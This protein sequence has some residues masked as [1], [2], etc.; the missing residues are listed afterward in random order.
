MMSIALS[1]TACPVCHGVE[2][3][4]RFAA[5]DPLSQDVFQLVRCTQCGLTY[6]NPRPSGD[7]LEAYYASSYYGNRH[8]ALKDT[9]MDLRARKI[10]LPE[11][12]DTV[13]DLGCGSGDFLLACRRRGW[14]TIGVEQ[15]EA[16]AVSRLRDVGIRVVSPDEM[17]SIG[18]NSINTVTAWHVLEHLPEP[19]ATFDQVRRIL[20]P[21]GRFVIEVPNFASWQARLGGPDWFHVDVPRH[22]LHFDRPSLATLLARSNFS[23]ER[24]STFSLEYDIFSLTQSLLNKVCRTP[25]HLFQL[26]IDHP[27]S[28]VVRDTLLS[29]TLVA[30]AAAIA[31]AISLVAP[32]SGNGGVLRVVARSNADA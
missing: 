23:A 25:N 17:D 11:D 24:W 7:Q 16:P 32:L 15:P 6:V 8:P 22:L 21:G 20:K 29:L 31:T 13:L 18:S 10:G 12:D 5:R 3:S 30:P 27:T 14:N 9:F 28:K 26:L 1:D 2:N 4:P 19:R